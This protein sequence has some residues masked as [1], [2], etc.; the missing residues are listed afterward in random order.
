MLNLTKVIA[1][2]SRDTDRDD[3]KTEIPP[4]TFHS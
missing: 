4:G 1:A 2:G 3:A